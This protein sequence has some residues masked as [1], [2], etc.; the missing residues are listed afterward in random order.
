LVPYVDDAVPRSSAAVVGQTIEPMAL[1]IERSQR[2]GLTI[3]ALSGRIEA[4]HTSELERLFGPRTRYASIVIDLSEVRLADRAAVRFLARCEV[5]G[6]RL[7]NCPGYI[8][9]W[10]REENAGSNE[11]ES[12]NEE[13]D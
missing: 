3:F 7:E 4:E 10:I 6:V 13:K 2:Q 12:R 11:Q 9:Q 8:R 5:D 1:R